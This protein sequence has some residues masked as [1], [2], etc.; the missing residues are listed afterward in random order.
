M[1]CCPPRATSWSNMP[2]IPS[3]PIMVGSRPGCG[4]CAVSHDSA[5]YRSSVPDMR[6]S[7]T[8][9]VAT[10]NSAW[11]PIPSN[12]FRRSLLN[13]PAPSEQRVS[14]AVPALS[15]V[16]ATDPSRSGYY[17]WLGRP[18]SPRDQ[19]NELLLKQIKQVHHDSRETYGSPR[20][21]AE[22][23]LGLGL[24][25]SVNL[26]RVARLMREAASRVSTGA[27]AAARPA[28]TRPG[29]PARIWS[30]ATSP[31]RPPTCCG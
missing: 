13:S 7:R 27:D 24:G 18:A 26:K 29:S 3:S 10:T 23:T 30:T 4:R 9:A 14:S 5:R 15:P 2:T 11:M 16:N 22:L 31:L 17:D 19:E 8:S 21:H 12:G 25:L 1:S 20:V 6:S 28:V